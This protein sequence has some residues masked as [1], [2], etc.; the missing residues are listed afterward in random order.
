MGVDTLTKIIRRDKVCHYCFR[1]PNRKHGSALQ[2]TKEHVVPRAF[3]GENHISNYVLACAKCNNDRGT[4][5]FYCSC[6][7]CSTLIGKALL[8]PRQLGLMFDCIVKRSRPRVFKTKKGWASQVPGQTI[9]YSPSWKMAME[10]SRG[11]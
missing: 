11:I 1:T 3:G 4:T 2:A 10:K 8:N 6:V 9:N 7:V 5:L